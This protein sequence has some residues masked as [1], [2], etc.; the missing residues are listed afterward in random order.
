MS[1]NAVVV[2]NVLW[3]GAGL[4]V[5]LAAGFL[6]APFLIHE[7]GGERNGLWV[8]VLLWMDSFQLLDLGICGSVGRNLAFYRARREPAAACAVLS[9]SFALLC[10]VAAVVLVGT[11]VA[12][13]LFLQCN[14][15]PLAEVSD[16][17][18]ALVILG[19]SV[20]LSFPLSVFDGSLWALQRFDLSNAVDIPVAL[21]R[22]GLTFLLVSSGHGLVSLAAL[23]LA[24][25]IGS[26][27]VKAL[28][29]Y[30]LEPSLRLRPGAVSRAA[31]RGLFGYSLW[32]FVLS[33]T[34]TL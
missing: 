29:V 18:W 13:L 5:P 19:V 16:V 2:R 1:N 20:A 30:R 14:D 22:T 10:V 32:A 21:A 34:R 28:C 12:P 15:V 8:L 23:A 27:L 24:A 4:L 6:L 11:T 26:G 33:L 25:R 17:S 3:N 7:L 31:A 9:T